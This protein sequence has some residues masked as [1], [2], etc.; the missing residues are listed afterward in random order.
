[1]TLRFWW[2]DTT[3]KSSKLGIRRVTECPRLEF[4]ESVRDGTAARH[5]PSPRPGP[6]GLG[7]REAARS[8]DCS[9]L[10][11]MG[12]CPISSPSQPPLLPGLRPGESSLECLG[13]RHLR[14][15]GGDTR[16]LKGGLKPHFSKPHTRCWASL[17]LRR[18]AGI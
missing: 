15:R 12:A 11:Q 4:Q 8:V 1:M 9:Q 2:R 16:P 10:S 6:V 3:H 18:Q 14:C 17:F 7:A 13:P 5:S